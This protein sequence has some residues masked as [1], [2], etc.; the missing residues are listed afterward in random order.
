MIQ[1]HFFGLMHA[2]GRNLLKVTY[3]SITITRWK[4]EC[5]LFLTSNYKQVG[6]MYSKKVSGTC[7]LNAQMPKQII[8]ENS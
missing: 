4:S 7:K 3:K 5:S 6:R 1:M 8:I 2:F